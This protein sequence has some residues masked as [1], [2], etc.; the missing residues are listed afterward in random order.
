[1]QRIIKVLRKRTVK[2]NTNEVSKA[3][4]NLKKT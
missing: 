4:I 1:M 3:E 2:V